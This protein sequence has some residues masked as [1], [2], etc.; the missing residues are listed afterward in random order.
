MLSSQILKT[1]LPCFLALNFAYSDLNASYLNLAIKTPRAQE[2]GQKKNDEF[3][4]YAQIC[5]DMAQM[6][7]FY[8][9]MMI[10]E[11]EDFLTRSAPQ[12]KQ[13]FKKYLKELGKV[14]SVAK[15]RASLSRGEDLRALNLKVYYSSIGL[16]SILKALLNDEFLKLTGGFD[17]SFLKDFDLIEF[18][19]GVKQA[20]EAFKAMN[21][22]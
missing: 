13:R 14:I 18:G 1:S 22:S 5:K 15:K 8:A 16:E 2:V 7:S 12:E 19:K 21:V 3:K 17:E 10:K 20:N 11:Q 9:Y 6:Y 4:K